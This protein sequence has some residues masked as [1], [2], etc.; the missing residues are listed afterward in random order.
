M[1]EGKYKTC[2][3]CREY[4]R[5]NHQKNKDKRYERRRKYYSEHRDAQ[6]EYNKNY[7]REH[8]EETNER[9]RVLYAKRSGAGV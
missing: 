7:R 9:K 8:S 3:R 5:Q 2:A 1:D 6:L 4:M